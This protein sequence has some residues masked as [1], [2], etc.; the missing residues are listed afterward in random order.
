MIYTKR[1]NMESNFVVNLG[2]PAH[3]VKKTDFAIRLLPL[4]VCDPKLFILNNQACC[5]RGLQVTV[6][7]PLLMIEPFIGH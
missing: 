3:F 6:N 1:K 2:V 4:L 5:H 7:L